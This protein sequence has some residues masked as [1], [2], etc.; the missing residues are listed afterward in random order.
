MVS[1]ADAIARGSLA[2]LTDLRLED[3]EIGDEGT[4]AFA[5]AVGSLARVM[6]LVGPVERCVASSSTFLQEIRRSTENAIAGL[7]A[8]A[9][10]EAE[11]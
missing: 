5:G 11:R 6:D 2:K 10:A 9:A 4:A 8:C 3:N 1:F 7:R